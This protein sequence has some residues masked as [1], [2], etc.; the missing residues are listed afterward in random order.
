M[1]WPLI[2]INVR[3]CLL[4]LYKMCILQNYWIF[5]KLASLGDNLSHLSGH[6]E[7]MHPEVLDSNLDTIMQGADIYVLI[8][9]YL[10]VV[11]LGP[12]CVVIKINS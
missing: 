5:Y 8:L 7:R 6:K 1:Q 11:Q 9:D 10:I 4:I 12:K 3:V 2:M